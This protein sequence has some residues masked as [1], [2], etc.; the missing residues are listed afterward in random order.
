MTTEH[1][2]QALVIDWKNMHVARYP[3]LR[4][5]HS[6]PNGG[7][8]HIKTALALKAEGQVAGI[9]DLQL[10]V[11]RH[12][13]IGLWVEMKV[14]R[15]NPTPEQVEK[16]AAL[17]AEGHLVKVCYSAEAAVETIYHYLGMDCRCELCLSL[18]GVTP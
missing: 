18:I 9:P 13:S 10:P 11:A 1:A 7:K 17:R 3:V 5:L 4:L 12:G 15:N 6:T 2:E 16:M 8:R 14:G